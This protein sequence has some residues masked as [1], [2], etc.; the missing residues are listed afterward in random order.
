MRLQE[1][2]PPAVPKHNHE[3]TPSFKSFWP[4]TIKAEVVGNMVTIETEE[5][6]SPKSALDVKAER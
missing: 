5:V 1:D 6:G 2:R 3:E 4:P